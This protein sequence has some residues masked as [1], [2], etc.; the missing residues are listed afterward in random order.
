MMQKSL[1]PLFGMMPAMNTPF[2][3]SDDIDL[4]GLQKHIDNA[5][6][7]GI[8]GFLLPVVASEVN[9]LTREERKSIVQAA[10]EVNHHRVVVIGGASAITQEQCLQNVRDLIGSGVDG[11]FNTWMSPSIFSSICY[12]GKA[13]S[14]HLAYVSLFWNMILIIVA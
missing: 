14:K 2:T 13:C 10:V 3:E 4:E 9:K 1:F 8:C 5:I 6:N 12:T 11:V 7:A